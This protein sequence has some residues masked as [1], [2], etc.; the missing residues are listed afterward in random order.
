[1]TGDLTNEDVAIL[2]FERQRWRYAG[3]KETAIRDT[4]GVSATRYY[5]RLGQ[6]IDNPAALAY[7]PTL[8][9]RLRRLREERA[10]RRS[11]RSA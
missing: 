9:N 3:A 10:A 1:V 6:L 4:F 7:D 2:A 8:V 11:R 5:Q